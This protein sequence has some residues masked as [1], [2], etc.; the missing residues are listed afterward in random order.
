MSPLHQSHK[1]RNRLDTALLT[2]DPAT[3][4]AALIKIDRFGVNW[5]A[6]LLPTR[7]QADTSWARS[8]P[9]TAERV[10]RLR[11]LDAEQQQQYPSWH[12]FLMP[13]RLMN[14]P[15]RPFSYGVWR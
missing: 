10:H 4:A 13:N 3:L 9:S 8:H 15:A 1:Q 6:L 7:S 11:A 5:W 12:P 2:H 14:Q